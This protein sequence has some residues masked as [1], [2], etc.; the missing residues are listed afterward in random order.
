M[1]LVIACFVGIEGA[2]VLSIIYYIVNKSKS[3]LVVKSN[4]F[5][6]TKKYIKPSVIEPL[7]VEPLALLPVSHDQKKWAFHKIQRK[8]FGDQ[9]FVIAS[10]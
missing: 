9:R 4:D 3:S 5:L 7:V 1:F 10:V 2:V 6:V 8:Y